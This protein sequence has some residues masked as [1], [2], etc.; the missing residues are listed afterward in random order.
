VATLISPFFISSLL[1]DRRGVTISGRVVAKDEYIVPHYSSWTR[2]MRVSIQYDPPGGAGVAFFN[3]QIAL[4]SRFDEL[5]KGDPIQLHYLRQKD[6][7]AMPGAKTLRQM[8]LLPMV[9][10]ADQNT[11]SGVGDD[12]SSHSLAVA[13]V[14][15]VGLTLLLCKALRI[16]FFGW[17]VA[18]AVLF[19]IASATI[20]EFPRPTAQPE[21][22]VR[23][24]EGVVKRL[25]RWEWLFQ[26]NR[27]HG[28][29][30]D[31]PIQMAAVQFVPGGRTEPVVAVDL[32]DD[33]SFPGLHE[34]ALVTM[35]YQSI[36]PRIAHI[37]GATR[38]FAQRNLKG[39]FIQAVAAIVVIAGLLLACRLVSICWKTF[40]RRRSA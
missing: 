29:A 22:D 8:H 13:L 36:N 1:I 26:D 20:A 25:D 19:A 7:P 40:P 6:L 37:K 28:L 15:M 2:I 33:G 3:P 9:R 11:W 35:E 24:A 14:V 4:E 5:K 31:Q 39:I 32:I 10:L 27:N 18:A 23:Q 16:P 12:M 21:R 30:M 34:H 17:A 38:R